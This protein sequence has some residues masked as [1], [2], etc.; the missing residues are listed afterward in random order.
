[1]Q[2]NVHVFFRTTKNGDSTAFHAFEWIL[3]HIWWSHDPQFANQKPKQLSCQNHGT[4]WRL[5]GCWGNCR[6][7]R[8][9][10][11]STRCNTLQHAAT[12][13]TLQLSLLSLQ[14]SKNTL[15]HAATRCTLQLSLS[16]LQLSKNML[17]HTATRCNTLQHIMAA[18]HCNT[19]WLSPSKKS[20]QHTAAYCTIMAAT[21]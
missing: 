17:Q 13:C 16:W 2:K 20:L 21:D 8:C 10:W 3:S 11:V 19:L 4:G 1:M 9:N 7:Y 14:L 15:Q 12:R 5:G 6:S 18:T